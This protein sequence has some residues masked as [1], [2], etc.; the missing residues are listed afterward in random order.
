MRRC[1][2]GCALLSPLNRRQKTLPFSPI[3]GW[4]C[5]VGFENNGIGLSWQHIP[6]HRFDI[7]ADSET[8][9]LFQE[10]LEVSCNPASRAQDR[11]MGEQVGSLLLS[12][13]LSAGGLL[14]SWCLREQSKNIGLSY[15]TK[16]PAYM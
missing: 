16:P 14:E 10:L 5:T 9:L 1:I 6:C 4:V 11:Q 7:V 2:L 13:A 3:D 15:L 8:L 12:G